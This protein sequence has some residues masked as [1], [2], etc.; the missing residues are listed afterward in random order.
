MNWLLHEVP[1]LGA[2]HRLYGLQPASRSFSFYI[3]IIKARMGEGHKD[4]DPDA[5]KGSVAWQK[6][7]LLLL[8]SPQAV[9]EALSHLWASWVPRQLW[10]SSLNGK[11]PEQAKHKGVPTDAL[12]NGAAAELSTAPYYSLLKGRCRL[13]LPAFRRLFRLKKLSSFLLRFSSLNFS[14]RTNWRCSARGQGERKSVSKGRS[15][16][17][18]PCPRSVTLNHYAGICDSSGVHWCV[19]ASWLPQLHS[20]SIQPWA[21]S[22]YPTQHMRRCGKDKWHSLPTVSLG[23]WE[24]L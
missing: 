23:I 3:R 17:A 13:S 20:C 21:P 4:D 5:S 22:L 10:P 1:V 15:L 8:F 14:A 7:Q 12:L 11:E 18:S 9:Q 6:A 2:I 19:K 16:P 24:W